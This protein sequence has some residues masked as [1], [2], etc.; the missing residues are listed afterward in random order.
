MKPWPWRCGCCGRLAVWETAITYRVPFTNGEE[1][2][3]ENV[4]VGRCDSCGE[5]VFYDAT[6]QAIEAGLN[7]QRDSNRSD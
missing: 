6:T 4:P 1:A 3:V 5:Y 2:I 7:A